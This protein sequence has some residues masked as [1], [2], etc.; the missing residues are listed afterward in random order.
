MEADALTIRELRRLRIGEGD[1]ALLVG[2]P[3]SQHD[4]IEDYPAV[5]LATIVRVPKRA[6]RRRSFLLE[7][8]AS[9]LE[10]AVARSS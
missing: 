7:G 3:F 8:I 10:T 9:T 2:F 4:P 6:S 1:E 5:R